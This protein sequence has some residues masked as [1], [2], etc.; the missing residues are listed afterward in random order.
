MEHAQAALAATQGSGP[1]IEQITTIGRQIG[2]FGY[3]AYDAF[4]WVSAS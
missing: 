3:L 1:A 4:V 2:Y